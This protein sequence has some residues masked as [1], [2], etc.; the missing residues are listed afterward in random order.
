MNEGPSRPYV[1]WL[2]VE[3]AV[4]PATLGCGE[5][6]ACCSGVAGGRIATRAGMQKIVNAQNQAFVPAEE[7]VEIGSEIGSMLRDS[8]ATKSKETTHLEKW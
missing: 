3:L 7:A 8:G 1:H 4:Q 2:R 5:R 6:L